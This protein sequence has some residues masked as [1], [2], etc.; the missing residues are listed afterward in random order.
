MRILL[1][2]DERRIAE[3]KSI[4]ESK[5]GLEVDL[6]GNG[7]DDEDFKD[8][9]T[10]FDLNADDDG[11][12]LQ[13]YAGLKNKNV[14]VCAVKES[15]AEM[16]YVQGIN[17]KC[18]LFGLNA[19]PTFL[20]RP[21]WEVS[22]YRKFEEDDLK[23]AMEAT[24]IGYEIVE[25]RVGM[26]APRVLFMIINEACYT[27]QEGTAGIE[28]I[29][30]GMQLGTNYPKGPFRWADEIGITDVFET[31]TALYEDT[32]EERYKVCPLLKTKYLRDQPFYKN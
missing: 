21:S 31:L 3:L 2:G 8:Y 29:D 19:L 13:Y 9:D 14:F 32:R 7:Y 24:G 16:V 26:V 30:L 22:L 4:L 18:R 25:D 5:E 23:K 6:A 17:V 11:E 20:S 10:I 28:D 12:M 15:L 1:I 27:L